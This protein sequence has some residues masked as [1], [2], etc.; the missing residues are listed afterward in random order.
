MTTIH[1]LTPALAFI[2][3]ERLLINAD[4]SQV[5]IAVK[6]AYA[7]NPNAQIL[8]FDAATSHVIDLDLRGSDA[9]IVARLPIVHVAD[10]FEAIQTTPDEN[11]IRGRGRPKLGVVP[12]EVTLLPRHWEW[13]NQQTGGASVALRKLVEEARRNTETKQQTRI[14]MDSTYRF[15]AGVA[16]HQPH[17]EEA[18]RALFAG[19]G[20]RFSAVLDAWPADIAQHARHLAQSAFSQSRDK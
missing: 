10:A 1:S 8:V 12:R 13:L 3:C 16:G 19:D 15:M 6:R 18:T 5:A 11:T 14:A 7:E 2:D 20:P 17:Y 9:E 4:L